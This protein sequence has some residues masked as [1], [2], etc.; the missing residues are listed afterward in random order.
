MPYA[1]YRS[2]RRRAGNVIAASEIAS[3]TSVIACA[4]RWWTCIEASLF[5]FRRLA[6]G[7]ELPRDLADVGLLRLLA[8]RFAPEALGRLAV[9]EHGA[10]L[11]EVLLAA[12]GLV[13]APLEATALRIAVP[14]LG[15]SASF[16]VAPAWYAKGGPRSTGP[17]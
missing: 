17:R 4:H 5:S 3:C 9:R 8:S 13:G 11:G 16:C 7:L 14:F 6:V 1:A 12:L 2:Q 15:S 10:R